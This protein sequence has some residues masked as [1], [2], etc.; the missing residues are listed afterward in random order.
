MFVNNQCVYVCVLEQAYFCIH[1]R[2][3]TPTHAS[4][5]SFKEYLQKYILGVSVTEG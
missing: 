4:E 2:A 5:K 3:P 1:A